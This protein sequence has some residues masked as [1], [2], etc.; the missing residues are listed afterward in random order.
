[1]KSDREGILCAVPLATLAVSFYLYVT[2]LSDVA[3]IGGFTLHVGDMLFMLTIIF[4]VLGAI[5]TW[6][7]SYSEILLLLMG[8]LVLLGFARGASRFGVAAAGI[9]ARE[10]VGFFA[11]AAFIYF[12]GRTID[13]GWVLNWVIWLGWGVAILGVV[14]LIFGVNTFILSS[15]IVDALTNPDTPPEWVDPRILNGAAALLLGQAGIISLSSA[16]SATS[17]AQRWWRA[18]AFLAFEATLLVSQQ[19]TATIATLAGL[20]V[21]IAA[22]PRRFRPRIVGA[23]CLL[24]VIAGSSFYAGALGLLGGSTDRMPK[25]ISMIIEEQGSYAWR[26]AQWNRYLDRYFDAGI[27]DQMI[28]QPLGSQ[29]VSVFE[30]S[31]IGFS[32]HNWYI[33]LLTSIGA[34]GLGLIAIVLLYAV[35]RGFHRLTGPAHDGAKSDIR[36]ALAIIASQAVYAWGYGLPSEQG[37][38]LAIALQMIADPVSLPK[39]VL[40]NGLPEAP[41]AYNRS[42]EDAHGRWARSEP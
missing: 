30:G 33:Q 6:Y 7:R 32:P 11:A 2:E 25:I 8:C 21:L 28:G 13:K 37:L 10:F 39:P 18:A 4:C 19:R 27:E 40:S 24:V 9:Q 23:A 1:M 12:W 36:L 34:V 38:L 14:R 26:L 5:T 17:R 29:R 41:Q 3:N 31:Q 35:L 15:D 22:L 42:R 16:L 20:G